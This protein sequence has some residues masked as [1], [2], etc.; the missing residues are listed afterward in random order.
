MKAK[1]LIVE[2]ESVVAAE[3]AC[4]LES[5]GYQVVGT[6]RNGDKALDFLA[7]REI[8]LALLDI[9]IKGQLSGIDLGKI[10]QQQY[11]F[12]HVFLTAHADAATLNAVK[13]TLPYGIFI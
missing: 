12:P 4:I 2:D 11:Q 8:D 7:N 13:E 5:I 3:I 1:I 9:N 10:I 6:V